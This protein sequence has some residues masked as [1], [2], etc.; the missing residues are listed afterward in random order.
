MEGLFF[1][2]VVEVLAGDVGVVVAFVV[3]V[4]RMPLVV[5]LGVVEAGVQEARM[6][7]NASIAKIL[8]ATSTTYTFPNINIAPTT[9]IKIIADITLFIIYFLSSGLPPNLLFLF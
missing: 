6:L 2:V 9:S 8:H 1:P 3:V 4:V 7:V 5:V